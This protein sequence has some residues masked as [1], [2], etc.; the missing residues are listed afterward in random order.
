[1]P[2]VT[3]TGTGGNTVAQPLRRVPG[4]GL[5]WSAA[6]TSLL[7]TQI[8]LLA[9]PLLALLQLHSSASTVGLLTAA[10]Y[11]PWL[12][13]S[14]PAGLLVDRLPR[15]PLLVLCDLIRLLILAAIPL[16]AAVHHLTVPVLIVLVLLAGCATVLFE[17]ASSVF[18]PEVVDRTDL[19]P[20]NA[21]LQTSFALA[22]VI[23]P[24]VAGLL[25][26]ATSPAN[27]VALDAVSFGI[28]ALLLL[29]V[30]AQHTV[31]PAP[32][33][34]PLR[35]ALLGGA[36]ALRRDPVLRVLCAYSGLFNLVANASTP[37][38]LTFLVRRAQLSPH[39]LGFVLGM[40]AVGGLAGA[41]MSSRLE[42]RLGQGRL[43]A[44]SAVILG[45]SNIPLALL[46]ASR[47]AAY[48]A[49]PTLVVL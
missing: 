8:T 22:Y 31:A 17:L 43:L 42:R 7:G 13:L 27:A 40:G 1:M 11:L 45:L 2:A 20:A 15:R 39:A 41:A 30:R 46:P 16:T 37:V 29:R 28:S 36:A 33:S 12:L 48:V 44:M 6:T 19:G 9:L 49:V 34:E 4:F 14:L 23:G 38:L 47:S 3:T 26:G 18:L 24:A 21:A 10:E 25:I 32:R 5:L 35:R